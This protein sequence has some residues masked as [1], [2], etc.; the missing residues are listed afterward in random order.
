MQFFQTH[1]KKHARKKLINIY[2]AIFCL[3]LN[4][5]FYL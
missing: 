5:V 3:T 4:G 2:E 1:A